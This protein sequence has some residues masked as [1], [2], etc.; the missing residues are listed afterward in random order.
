MSRAPRTARRDVGRVRVLSAVVAALLVA[1]PLQAYVPRPDRT[2]RAIAETN[3]QSGRSQAIQLELTMRVGDREPVARGQLISHPTGLA[4]LELRGFNGR[5][6]RYLLSGSELVGAKD[7]LRL[8]QPQPLLQPI[9]LLQPSSATTLRAAI[10]TFGVASD[11]IGLAP[12]GDL[13]CFVLGDPRL[14][15]PLPDVF[16]AASADSVEPSEADEVLADPLA[17]PDGAYALAATLDGEADLEGDALLAGAGSGAL[18]GPE[19]GIA[20]DAVLP[21]LWVDTEA[22]QVRRID[23][24]SG[25][26]TVF[27]PVVAFDRLQVPAWFEIHDPGAEPIRFEVDRAVQVNAPAQAFSRSWVFAPVV[28]TGGDG[29]PDAEAPGRAAG[30]RPGSPETPFRASPGYDPQ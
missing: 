26:Y 8:D 23:R 22:L 7:G 3:R 4:R 13:D 17:E 1:A 28:P 14:A 2:I 27:G 18:Q 24:A 6:D 30:S 29:A 16:F 9:F 5:V 21:R 15:A 20:E 11:M 25:V 12:C 10:E 19:L